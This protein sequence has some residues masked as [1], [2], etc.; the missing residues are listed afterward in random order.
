MA[1]L[2]NEKE[3]ADYLKVDNS[4]ALRPHILT[5]QGQIA[6]AIR[7]DSIL[8]RD[9]TE[10]I[11]PANDANLIILRDGPLASVTSV[12]VDGTTLDLDTLWLRKWSIEK[13]DEDFPGGSTIVV[14]YKAGY[15]SA[16]IPDSLKRALIVTAAAIFNQPNLDLVYEKIGDY[17]RQTASG[18][19]GG[20]GQSST[21]L[22]PAAA[23]LIREFIRPRA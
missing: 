10:T 9:R 1:P 12:T 21:S 20:Q 15:T 2:I 6:A 19:P 3:V 18:V 8:E 16:T 4:P 5:A 17:T 22:N 11:R 14:V 23:E 7:V 13:T